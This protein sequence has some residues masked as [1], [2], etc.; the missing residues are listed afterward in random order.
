MQTH[1]KTKSQSINLTPE[2]MSELSPQVVVEED[3]PVSDKDKSTLSPLA[4]LATLIKSMKP[5]SD[6][7]KFKEPEPF[8][9]QDP[10][11]L[12]AFIFQ[13]QLYFWS[14]SD[15]N[16]STR[17]VNFALSY[18]KDV[19]QEWFE[20][21]ISGLTSEPPVWLSNW[22]A[23]VE[24]LCH[25][26]GPFDEQG[27]AETELMNLHMRD[28]QQVSNYL[29][30]FSALSLRCA[31]GESPLKFRFYE[32][33]PN[34]IKDKLSKGEGKHQPLED[35]Q[36]AAQKLMLIIGNVYKNVLANNALLKNK[37]HRKRIPL[38]LLLMYRPL[39]NPDWSIKGQPK[40]KKLQNRPLWEL[41]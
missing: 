24:E 40:P 17:Q 35:L 10:K 27:D 25:N 5:K 22:D 28:S 31:W 15:F 21:G 32:G 8:T 20:P 14:S 4:E 9:G 13:C 1:A 37:I 34:R 2:L 11:K 26:F 18:L 3:I 38:P 30:Q 39:L 6:A 33:L 41:I 36:R 23:F 29:I 7:G 16:D 12:K 19:A